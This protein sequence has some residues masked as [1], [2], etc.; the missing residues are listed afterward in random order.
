MT[1]LTFSRSRCAGIRAVITAIVISAS[2]HTL[3]LFYFAGAAGVC[4]ILIGHWYLPPFYGLTARN[5]HVLV[6][7]A[8]I[9]VNTKIVSV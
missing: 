6:K 5:F 9:A 8:T 2:R 1:T 4:A 3:V 7:Y